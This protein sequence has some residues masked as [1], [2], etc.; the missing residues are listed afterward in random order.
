MAWTVPMTWVANNAL[1][2]AQL[3]CHLRDNLLETTPAKATVAGQ[4]FAALSKY[5][6]TARTPTNSTVATA[7]STTSG[8]WVDLATGGPAVT[9]TTGERA[10]VMLSCAMFN[11]S[12][13]AGSNMS[14]MIS[15]ATERDPQTST[16]IRM[17]GVTA[18]D[19]LSF[20]TIDFITTLTPGS[21]TFTAKYRRGS[22]TT[23]FRDRQIF[24]WPF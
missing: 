13:N 16:S 15:G 6:I 8:D 22:G 9:V 7:E 14:Y 2:A 23:T 4:M 19:Q 11:T 17:D 10:I 21:N 12:A 24:V 20:G 1:T 3:N 5:H 18:S